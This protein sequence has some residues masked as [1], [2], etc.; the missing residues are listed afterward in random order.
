[1]R[2]SSIWPPDGLETSLAG[3]DVLL[4]SLGI[5]YHHI[6]VNW[7]DPRIEE[8][9]R[10]EALMGSLAGKR[11]LIH[12]RANYRVTAF[13]AMYATAKLDWDD[14]RADA[15]MDRIWRAREDYEMDANWKNF[16]AAARRR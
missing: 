9:E 3:E 11:T 15:L 2:S 6:P 5:A 16:I 12:C 4:E 13:Y 14:A 10:F 8:L 1:M 7:A